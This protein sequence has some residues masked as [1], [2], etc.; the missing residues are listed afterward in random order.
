MQILQLLL[1]DTTAAI[2]LILLTYVKKNCL[3]I[4]STVLKKLFLQQKF[5]IATGEQ[6]KNILHKIIFPQK[7]PVKILITSG[8]SCPDAVVEEVIEKLSGFFTSENNIEAL[9]EQF[10]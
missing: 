1:A 6:K 8:A 4:L 7:Q 5:C 2:L 9:T 3:L 10:A